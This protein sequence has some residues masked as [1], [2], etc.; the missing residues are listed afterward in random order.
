MKT[1]AFLCLVA[2]LFLNSSL[3]SKGPDTNFVQ[4]KIYFKLKDSSPVRDYSYSGGST[5]GLPKVIAELIKAFNVTAIKRPFIQAKSAKLDRIFSLSF[6]DPNDLPKVIRAVASVPGIEYAEPIPV[7]RLFCTAD[8]VWTGPSTDY[9]H[10]NLVQACAAWSTF[11]AGA[12]VR[13]AILDNECD[14][15]HPDLVGKITPADAYDIADGD[16]FVIGN[17]PAF[18]HGT[19]V[20]GIVGAESNTFGTVGLGGVNP[21]LRLMFGKIANSTG[22]LTAGYSGMIWAVTNGADVINCSWGS[23]EF[24]SITNSLVTAWVI[25]QGVIIVAAAGNN[26]INAPAFPAS[27]PGVY[28]VAASDQTDTKASFSNW[29]ST[30][31]ISAPGVAIYSTISSMVGAGTHAYMSGTSMAS[32]MVAALAGLVKS[33][34][35]SYTAAQVLNCISSTTDPVISGVPVGPGRINAYEALKC[36]SGASDY[37]QFKVSTDRICPGSSITFGDLSVTSSPVVNWDWTISSMT[38][39]LTA[40][41]PN[42]SVSFSS[43]GIYHAVLTVTCAS[44]QTFTSYYPT[45]IHVVGINTAAISSAGS[46]CKNGDAMISL[47]MDAWPELIMD[48]DI[49]GV[50]APTMT[51][52]NQYNGICDLML[53]T[54]NAPTMTVKITNISDGILSCPAAFSMIA[55]LVDCCANLVPNGNFE[56]GLVNFG[57]DLTLCPSAVNPGFGTMIASPPYPP[58]GALSYHTDG[59]TPFAGMFCA[60]GFTVPPGGAPTSHYKNSFSLIAGSNYILS[61]AF[62]GANQ[63]YTLYQPGTYIFPISIFR[64]S[65]LNPSAVAVFTQTWMP[66]STS[67]GKWT[68]FKQDLTGMISA[69][70]S[71][72][73]NVEQIINFDGLAFDYSWDDFSVT[74]INTLTSSITP[75]LTA[76]CAPGNASMTVSSGNAQPTLTYTWTSSPAGTYPNTAGINPS[77][78]ATTVY[79]ATITDGNFCNVSATSTVTVGSPTV[80]VSNQTICAGTSATLTASGATTYTWQPGGLIGNPVVVT[81]SVTT[82]YTVTGTTAGCT[83]ST[84]AIVTASNCAQTCTNC[85][86]I[87]V[88]GVIT[89]VTLTGNTYCINNNV[90]ISGAVN[91]SGCEIKMAP[92]V[93]VTIA[94]GAFFNVTNTHIYSC[95]DMWQGMVIQNGGGVS[96]RNSLVEDAITAVNIPNN[97]QTSGVLTVFSSTFNKNYKG[98]VITNYA[99]AIPTFPFTIKTSVFTCR[100]IKF[101]PNSL[102]FPPTTTIGAAASNPGAPF[103]NPYISNSGYPEFTPVL[104]YLKAPFAGLKSNVG[105]ELNKVG[106]TLNPQ[107]TSPTYY[108]FSIGDSGGNNIFDNQSYGINA[109]NANLS[110]FNN[111]FQNSI[112]TAGVSD[113]IGINS[114]CTNNDNYRLRVTSATAATPTQGN[115]FVDCSRDI[116]TGNVFEHEITYNDFRSSQVN[117]SAPTTF[118]N[119]RGNYGIRSITNRYRLYNVSNNTMYNLENAVLMEATY[120]PLSIPT[121]PATGQYAGKIDVDNNIISAQIGA[122]PVTTQYVS[123]AVVLS[124]TVGGTIYPSTPFPNVPVA[125]TTNNKMTNVY[126]GVIYNS[127]TKINSTITFND[128]RLVSDPYNASGLP[129][130]FGIWLNTSQPST[131]VNL[132]TGNQVTGFT[133]NNSKLYGIVT[134]KSFNTTVSCNKTN[135]TYSGIEFQGNCPGTI[136]TNNTMSNHTYGFVLSNSGFI[137]VQGSTTSPSDN[138]WTGTW[139]AGTFKTAT[140]GSTAIGSELWVRGTSGPTYNPNGSGY[141][142][143]GYG[144]NDYYYV[145]GNT[146]TIKFITT[147]PAQVQCPNNPGNVTPPSFRMAGSENEG[148]AGAELSQAGFDVLI[149]PNP[150]SNEFNLSVYGMEDMDLDI[151]I[152]DMTGKIVYQNKHHVTN[153]LTHFDIDVANGVYTVKINDSRAKQLLIKKLVV[154]K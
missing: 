137:G 90:T 98:I 91:I 95:T 24:F 28:S 129:V 37:V 68:Q 34:N 74:A 115:Q 154:Q 35:P 15:N 32:P 60:P 76:L 119:I 80:T 63:Q 59:P 141:T 64:V 103:T 83:N 44:T 112:A 124:N 79:T 126:R 133:I 31:D 7:D 17:T 125:R 72:S 105:I 40:T 148:D 153:A 139:P 61:F 10:L 39:T 123:N 89:P 145:P 94:P 2:A 36:S 22:A 73:L 108:E 143:S 151:S 134:N 111:V 130:Q 118:V 20:T 42:P 102:V 101:T 4:G 136:F 107:S 116:N 49:N 92:N 85:I 77:V 50:P 140:I 100:D 55:P 53:T 65:L 21:N 9:Y 120:G 122:A 46:F 147:N 43:P 99:Q 3:F 78:S 25:S 1:H 128:I 81:P 45:D 48:Y 114:N 132:I 149:Y 84:T 96:L 109:T 146:G 5:D 6:T 67:V 62:A 82:T 86:V 51:V 47:T 93:V 121:V 97:T 127:W 131:N 18:N 26:N 23:A 66:N 106:T 12:P 87:G 13:V 38:N 142:S 57:S 16:P 110:S 30:V 29:G 88:G 75:S 69:T 113:G 27:F 152:S 144:T 138:M 11:P 150:G 104:S 19:H 52:V 70:G 41:G 8:P 33:N 56:S 117:T 54:P 71:Y 58:R 14:I 135:T